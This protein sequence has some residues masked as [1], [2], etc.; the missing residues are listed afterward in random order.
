[1]LLDNAD[2]LYFTNDVVNFPKALRIYNQLTRRLIFL[3]ALRTANGQWINDHPMVK[4]F[5][6]LV[7][8]QL[9]AEPLQLLFTIYNTAQKRQNKLM[10]R[11]DLFCHS[12]DWVP[13]LS[14]T[15]YEDRITKLIRDFGLIETLF[16]KYAKAEQKEQVLSQYV[17]EVQRVND[18]N[19]QATRNQIERISKAG[20]EL[21]TAGIVIAQYT[22]QLRAGRE[23]MIATLKDLTQYIENSFH[24]SPEKVVEAMS[25]WAMAP[26]AFFG[27]MTGLE[28]AYK[29]WTSLENLQ[30]VEVR[31]EFVVDQLETCQG[32]V[33]SLT[34]TFK[35]LRGELTVDS[36]GY[37]KILATLETV[38]KV[39]EDFKKVIPADKRASVQQELDNFVALILKRN[40]AVVSYNAQL[41]W[42]LHLSTLAESYERES[43]TLGDHALSLNP[44]LPTIYFW[45]K[46]MKATMQLD[47]LQR[48]NYEGRALAFWGPIDIKT[49]TFDPPGPL[50]GAV[51]L[52]KHQKRLDDLFESCCDAFS[53]GT[54][55]HWPASRDLLHTGHIIDISSI[56]PFLKK[57]TTDPDG[58]PVHEA[59]FS[60][61]PN[62]IKAFRTMSNV[63]IKQVRVWCFGATVAPNEQG[64][65]R[66]IIDIHHLGFEKI[67]DLQGQPYNFDHSPVVLQFLY[68]TS[69]FNKNMKCSGDPALVFSRQDIENDYSGTSGDKPKSGDRPPMGPFAD[70]KISIYPEAH[71]SLNLADVNKVWVEFCGRNQPALRP[72]KGVV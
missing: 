9:T 5:N 50:D 31:K 26:H 18:G 40:N 2:A 39:L 65:S 13:R 29:S 10:L 24:V 46:R 37:G 41:Q 3:D 68:E 54:W 70:W 66:L 6:N 15:F 30:G 22:P 28:V 14:M 58:R 7:Y 60:I 8:L 27:V 55:T 47:I 51:Q 25:S 72:L 61:S 59:S 38:Q 32:T 53:S 21:E 42:L 71:E 12:P 56:I 17:K 45:L 20:G 36:P 69:I 33:E 49:V 4:S 63:R 11:K 43:K 57:Q 16:E 62:S 1:M 23:K 48:L 44:Q 34:E 19:A 67:W 52:R 64:E 35:H